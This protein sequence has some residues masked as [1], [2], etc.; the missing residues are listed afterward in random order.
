[1]SREYLAIP[2]HEEIID[3]SPTDTRGASESPFLTP[4]EA[5]RDAYLGAKR[6]FFQR[7]MEALKKKPSQVDV[8]F[9]QLENYV[10]PRLFDEDVV[11]GSQVIEVSPN[12]YGEGDES[13]YCYSIFITGDLIRIGVFIPS[14]KII[15]AP[16][17]NEGR[18]DLL[19]AWNGAE[20]D[21]VVRGNGL[22]YEWAFTDFDA[23]DWLNAERYV[24]GI[25]HMHYRL[26]GLVRSVVETEIAPHLK[27][28]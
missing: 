12:F 10:E 24:M 2:T 14:S 7:V 20:F 28:H 23:R 1:M 26:L 27:H 21:V 13:R 22:M 15:S 9:G 11:L 3:E 4:H 6:H 8:L 5:S 17:H 19:Q 18:S 16:V 25:R